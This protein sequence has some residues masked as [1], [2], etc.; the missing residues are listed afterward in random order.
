MEARLIINKD[1]CEESLQETASG[2][3]GRRTWMVRT[4]NIV[5]AM[6]ADGL[7][8]IG[9]SWSD[10][11]PN[12]R[13]VARGPTK[14]K[15]G[16]DED[17]SGRLGTL[18]VPVDYETPQVGG[19]F[20]PASEN[21]VW[22]EVSTQVDTLRRQYPVERLEPAGGDVTPILNGDG[23]D[24]QGLSVFLAVHAYFR[25]DHDIPWDVMLRLGYP[26]VKVNDRP[27]TIPNIMHT[28]RSRRF[29]AGQLLFL[30]PQS[31]EVTGDF[32]AVTWNLRAAA[33]FELIWQSEDDRGRAARRYRDRIYERESFSGLW[34]GS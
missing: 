17:S 25:G 3:R 5:K 24:T 18:F 15:G 22:T 28:G 30:G 20:T 1:E 32:L 16:W 34:P 6:R 2:W 26:E 29:D 10:D 14:L 11:M 12:L 4:S 31:M 23:I 33:N 8:E 13:V 19:R 27:V 21:D 7:P 9:D